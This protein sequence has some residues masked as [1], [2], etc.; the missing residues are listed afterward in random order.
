MSTTNE[1]KRV[2]IA[3]ACGWQIGVK[4]GDWPH[5]VVNPAGEVVYSWAESVTDPHF[6]DSLPDYFG[7]L[8]AIHSAERA[9]LETLTNRK[10]WLTL[11]DV[12]GNGIQIGH[13]SATAAQYAEAFGRTLNLWP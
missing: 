4:T 3:E 2:L 8:N 9:H 11:S 13:W 7:D 12:I 10:Y 5:N 1:E 6:I